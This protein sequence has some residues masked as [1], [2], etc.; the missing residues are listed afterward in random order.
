MTARPVDDIFLH[1]SPEALSRKGSEPHEDSRAAG[2]GVV[3]TGKRDFFHPGRG[4][5][6]TS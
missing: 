1:L 2:H 5:T 6:E 4:E 3:E